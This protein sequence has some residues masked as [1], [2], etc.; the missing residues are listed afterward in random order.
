MNFSRTATQSSTWAF[1]TV[2][3]WPL[4]VSV[5]TLIATPFEA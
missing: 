4:I 2:T 3:L 1:A 5:M